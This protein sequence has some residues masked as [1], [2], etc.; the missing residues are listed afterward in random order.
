MGFTTNTFIFL[1]LP[2]VLA[3]YFSFYHYMVN[4]ND[5]LVGNIIISISSYIF[6]SWALGTNAIVLLGYTI[7]IYLIGSVLDKSKEV[8]ITINYSTSSEKKAKSIRVA[9]FVLVIGLF[10]S[11]YILYHFKYASVVEPVISWYFYVD[12]NK[13]TNITVPLGISFITF[14]A[15]TYFADIYNKKASAGSFIDCFMYIF[16][17]PK[18]VSGP[19]VPWSEFEPQLKKRSISSGSFVKGMNRL[20]I[21]FAKK[22]ILADSFG[23]FVN[24]INGVQIDSIT[25]WMGWFAYTLQIYYDFSGYSDMAIGLSKM[26]GIDFE[27]NFNFPYRSCSITEFWRRWHISLGSFFR[28]YVYIPLGGNRKGKERTLIN[29][30]IVFLITG[31]WHGAGAV[32]LLWGVVHGLFAIVERV[33]RDRNWY[34]KIPSIL[35]W[36]ITF[37]TVASL[38]QLFRFGNL[39]Q[40]ITCFLQMIGIHSSYTF[41]PKTWQYYATNRLISFMIIGFI[42]STFLGSER[43]IQLYSKLKERLACYIVQ[44]LMLLCLLVVSI[45]FM[46]NSTYSPFIYFQF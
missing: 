14:S 35:K 23:A 15:I 28:N 27:E 7:V 19:I 20:I 37:V 41:V 45:A 38:W 3:L 44:E 43:I 17:F 40:T 34:K 30:G 2:L 13:Y 36:F 46:I 31:I 6:Y 5:F 21:G 29:L 10:F 8:Q 4:K 39:T 32:Y 24:S 11:L 18:V 12:P 9:I 33:I 22:V 16:Y 42:G 25:A 26:F 1:F